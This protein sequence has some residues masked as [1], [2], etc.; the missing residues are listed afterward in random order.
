MM[1]NFFA[2]VFKA[3]FGTPEYRIL[4][5]GLDAAGKTTILYKLKLGEPVTTI[6]TIGF[7]I[8][9]VEYNN[10]RLTCWDVGGRSRTQALWRSYYHDTDAIIF[11]VDS[12]DK[13]RIS[14]ENGFDTSAKE[15]LHRMLAAD[16][17][18][19]AII[20]VFGNKQDLSNA[21]SVEEITDKLELNKLENREWHVQ[22]CCATTGDGLYEGLDWL[23]NKL[24]QRAPK[25]KP[26]KEKMK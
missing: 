4:M 10:I 21:M 25:K 6:P 16:D 8:E 13:V 2:N 23:S 3:I 14:D 26:K 24:N 15:E 17:L 1:G 5:L 22:G 19:D 11:V 9:T 12:N 18:N 20:L 7:N